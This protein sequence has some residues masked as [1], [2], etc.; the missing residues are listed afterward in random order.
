MLTASIGGHFKLNQMDYEMDIV[1]SNGSRG[2]CQFKHHLRYDAAMKKRKRLFGVDILRHCLAFFVVIE[3]MHSSSRYSY[4]TNS[5]IAQLALL[6]QGAVLAFFLISG[7]FFQVKKEANPLKTLSRHIQRYS[8]RLL[9]PFAIFSFI[10]AI[11]LLGMKK[12]EF[13]EVVK[14]ILIGH[15][16]GP[17][18]Y[19]LT[20]LFLIVTIGATIQIASGF[21][22]HR[23]IAILLPLAV[24]LVALVLHFPTQ[25][26]TGNDNI[27][28]PLYMLSF[29][30]GHMFALAQQ[31]TIGHS[32]WRP[33][34]IALTCTALGLYDFRF[35]FLAGS[36]IAFAVSLHL[37]A[38]LP[39]R[40][41]P[42]SGGV[43]LLHT[44]IVNF[45]V[46]AALVDVGVAQWSNAMVSVIFTY[47]ACLAFSKWFIHVAPSLRWMLL[48]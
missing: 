3:H 36:V 19:F 22:L 32:I 6:V 7:Y 44:P 45:G 4:A 41:G 23:E 37:S 30:T 11:A 9:I 17:Q 39:S 12:I 38:Y 13:H 1:A 46:S 8:K 33:G 5:K 15:G 48:E 10:N 24:I 18:L 26:V 2:I 35:Y 27:L 31:V 14:D 43:Y 42:G 34:C 47:I 28:L 21:S 20:F 25:S 40:R 29:M 16:V